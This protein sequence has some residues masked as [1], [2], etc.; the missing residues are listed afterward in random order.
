[1]RKLICTIIACVLILLS[2][3]VMALDNCKIS[4]DDVTAMSGGTVLVTLKMENNPGVAIG[5][6]KLG[7]DK[8][9]L[10]PVSAEKSDILTNVWSFTS[11][12]DDPNTDP[13][14]LDYVTIS[15]MNMTDITGD[16]KLAVI[17][18]AVK[19]NVSGTTDIQVEVNELA[20][21]TQDNITAEVAAGTIA[22]NSGSNKEPSDD[23]VLGFS[24]TTV[25]K[26]STSIGGDVNLSVYSSEPISASFISTIYD[27]SGKLLAVKTKNDTLEAGVND[28]SLG[29]INANA[30]DE[31]SYFVKVYM[32]NS[33]EGMKPL[34]NEPIIKRY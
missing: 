30:D 11:N 5:K 19:E 9:K 33:L 4:I 18:F 32:W 13:T 14:E 1:M 6:I 24:T 17:E 23:I 8:E 21:D 12:I 7:F 26:T 3:P 27:N 25:T 22:F 20:K 15:W 34:T 2:L 16:G 31:N 10:L 28:V 29:E